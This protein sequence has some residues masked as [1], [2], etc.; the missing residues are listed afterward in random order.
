MWRFRPMYGYGNE[1]IYATHDDW[2]KALFDG[3]FS[4]KAPKSWVYQQLLIGRP[5]IAA[6]SIWA[7]YPL[8]RKWGAWA[9]ATDEDARAAGYFR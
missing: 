1:W 9:D 6:Y 7:K 2:L 4:P 5:A 3:L 8:D